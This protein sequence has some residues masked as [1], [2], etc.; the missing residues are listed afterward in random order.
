[1]FFMLV[2]TKVVFAACTPEPETKLPVT[3]ASVELVSDA[4]VNFPSEGGEGE[5]VFDYTPY[6]DPNI[7]EDESPLADLAP[8]K[9][10]C[11]AE[12]IE[13]VDG[14]ETYNETVAYRVAANESEESREA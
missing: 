13:F 12:W 9:I 11:E 8:F 1:M 2:A 5:I 10:T 7:P 14:K 3:E 6:F 4:V